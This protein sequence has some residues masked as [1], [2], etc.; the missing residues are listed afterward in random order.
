MELFRERLIIK[1]RAHGY[2]IVDR[3]TDKKG[4]LYSYERIQE[5]KDIN[6][7]DSE[8]AVSLHSPRADKTITYLGHW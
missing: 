3:I 4:R 1:C 2:I 6:A 5:G 8:T 7:R